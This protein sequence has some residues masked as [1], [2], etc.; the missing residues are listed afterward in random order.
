[1]MTD[2]SILLKA[3]MP[4]SGRSS[5]GSRSSHASSLRASGNG[6]EPWQSTSGLWRSP[7]E[8]YRAPAY[9]RRKMTARHGSGKGSTEIH[10]SS[11]ASLRSDAVDPAGPLQTDSALDGPSRTSVVAFAVLGQAIGCA[12]FDKEMVEIVIVQ[13][14]ALGHSSL[15]AL[16]STQTQ[17][18]IM[19][20]YIERGMREIAYLG[21]RS[22]SDTLLDS[23]K[24]R[25]LRSS[26]RQRSA[27][28]VRS[29]KR[30]AS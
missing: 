21:Q 4:S 18:A 28:T 14:Q 17:E 15:D 26:A 19:S 29:P 7:M 11:V 24:C 12:Y 16:S 20:R 10:R 27:A 3:P 6:N 9:K 2:R 5:D 22:V 13:D 30:A 1:M 8:P 23:G 25:R